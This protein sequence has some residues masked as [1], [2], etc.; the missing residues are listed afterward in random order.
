MTEIKR[1]PPKPRPIATKRAR[2]L[3][4]SGTAVEERLWQA[5][6]SRQLDK[7]KFHRQTPIGSYI[8]D[9]VCIERKLVIELDGGQ[10]A[11]RESRDNIRT[12]AIEGR[13]YR[14][15]RFWNHEVMENF[16]GV[17]ERIRQA[18]SS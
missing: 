2:T 13:G 4:R 14:V 9:F 3:R 16:D 17:I 1:R 12:K 15:L 5:L 6:R 11:E 10:H 18:L 7:V 8:V